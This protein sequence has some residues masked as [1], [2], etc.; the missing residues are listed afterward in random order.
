M[1]KTL[2]TNSFLVQIAKKNISRIVKG[3]NCS[4]FVLISKKRESSRTSYYRPTS[5]I[6]C[7]YKVLSKMLTNRLKILINSIISETHSAF[8][9]GRQIL[10]GVLVANEIMDEARR[11]KK[12]ERNYII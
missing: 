10:D 8:I 9:V 6:G 2:N 11:K 1:N 12:E 4:F 7:I 5:F 3:A